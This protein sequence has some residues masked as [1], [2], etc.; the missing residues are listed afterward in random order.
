MTIASN[1]YADKIFAEQPSALWSL[2]DD[3]SVSASTISGIAISDTKGIPA[4]SYG[5]GAYPGYYITDSFGSSYSNNDGVPMVYGATNITTIYPN[6]SNADSPSLILPAFGFMNEL[7]KTRPITYEMWLR[8]SSEASQPKKI[9][10]PIG[11]DDG[12]YVYGSFLSLR[13]NGKIYS[14]PVGSWGRPMLIQITVAQSSVS[15]MLNG[16]QIL[17]EYYDP[18]TVV[19]ASQYDDEGNNQDWVGFYAYDDVM[20]INIDCC[21]VYPFQIPLLVAKKRFAYGQAVKSPEFGMSLNSDVP[22]IADFQFAEYAKNYIY[23]D[24]GKWEQGVFNNCSFKNNNLSTP[25]YSL[26]EAVF[27]N[28]QSVDTWYLKQNS[29][30]E[31]DK[32]ETNN[33]YFKINPLSEDYSGYLFFKNL[34]MLDQPIASIY[35]VFEIGSSAVNGEVLFEI[36]GS[37][38]QKFS[39]KISES[40]GVYSLSYVFTKSDSSTVNIGGVENLTL[41]TKFVAGLNIQDLLLQTELDVSFLVPFF[42][43]LNSLSLYIGGTSNFEN[44]FSGKVYR[45]GFDNALTHTELSESYTFGIP[46]FDD[47]T[48]FMNH[49]AAYTLFSTNTFGIFGLDIAVSFMW[50][51]YM[52]LS[53]FGK[54]VV[55]AE[56]NQTFDLD[57]LQFNIDYPEP[58]RYTVE[59][60][61]EQ[62]QVDTSDSIVKS[63]AL[64]SNIGS[65]NTALTDVPLGYGKYIYP[66]NDWATERYELVNESVIYMPQ[67][68]D[69]ETTTDVPFEELQI[70][71]LIEGKVPGILRNPIGIRSV[72][73]SSQALNID[74]ETAIGSKFGK[75]AYPYTEIDEA[76]DYKVANPVSVYTGSTP[77]LYMDHYSGVRLL[78]DT[79]SGERGVLIKINPEASDY[80]KLS[81]IQFAIKTEDLFPLEPTKIFEMEDTSNIYYVYVDRLDGGEEAVIYVNKVVDGVEELFNGVKI[82]INGKE[83]SDSQDSDSLIDEQPIIRY[84]EWNIIGVK[85]KSPLNFSYTSDGYISFVGP[86]IFNNINSFKVNKIEEGARIL[87][88]KWS[89][90]DGSDWSA[91]STGSWDN[92]RVLSSTE[93][94]GTDG[95]KAYRTYFGSNRLIIDNAESVL[96]FGMYEYDVYPNI[97]WKTNSVAAV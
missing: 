68:V 58:F 73:L 20:P 45:F 89:D 46:A 93:I 47:S 86:F 74:I 2:D 13:F 78:G 64:L 77:Y 23:P 8:I 85:F 18:E 69:S 96:G 37:A 90:V 97:V 19:L 61:F 87:F 54:N 4:T 26:P 41:D 28:N 70:L 55:D 31:Y 56:D 40:G 9:F 39:A 67:Y 81:L 34:N 76:K 25:E 51:D 57:F 92:V 11:S 49:Y 7:G 6:L 12:L 63:Y 24:I 72:R 5:V 66:Y 65:E 71:I 84:K 59:S 30:G 60:T 53:Y 36:A 94:P 44:T 21:A 32:L 79:L 3:L 91:Y 22:F 83:Y 1:L 80:Y 14:H 15:L 52:P 27:S 33:L 10:G 16:E 50:R 17:S 75:K 42:S 48:L 88:R 62:S 95:T 38:G 43:N 35:G 82:Y 29:S